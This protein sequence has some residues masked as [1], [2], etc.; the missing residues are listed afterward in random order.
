MPG[1]LIIPIM[2]IFAAGV[3]WLAHLEAERRRKMWAEIA[4]RHGFVHHEGDPLR[5]RE[6]NPGFALFQVGHSK[7]V[8]HTLEGERQG[9][10]VV[11][12]DY[13]Y[14]TGSGKHQATH[15]RTGVLA[16][17]PFHAPRLRIRPE[18]LGDAFAA[19]LG[20]D[21]ID[22]ESD[23]FNR[24]YHVSSDDKRFAYD[25]CHPRLMEFLVAAEGHCWELNGRRLLFFS[26]RMKDFDAFELEHALLL[27]DGFLD[28]LP[29]HLAATGTAR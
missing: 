11:V 1:W 14:T 2:V 18:H 12:F 9:R 23:L 28:R 5:L 7:R 27:L 3:L 29:A 6:Q 25:V 8:L 10:P 26:N 16:D 4:A 24:K 15:R 21:D 22:F 13:R 20:F 19:A 17:L